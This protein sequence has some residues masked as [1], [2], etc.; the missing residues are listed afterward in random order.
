VF[1]TDNRVMEGCRRLVELTGC[2]CN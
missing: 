2:C 1:Y